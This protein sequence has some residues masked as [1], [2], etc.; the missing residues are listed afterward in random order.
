MPTL[1]PTMLHLLAPFAPCFSRRVWCHALVLVAGAILA[2]GRRTV[3]AA[4]RAMG[5]EH[6]QR[7][8]RYHRVLSR[9]EW[10]GLAV[11]RTLLGLLVAA[12]VPS[13]PLVV[14]VDETVERRRGAQDRGQGDLPR[15]GALQPRPLRQGERAALGLPDAAGAHPVGAPGV[16]AA[17]PD[18]PGPLRAL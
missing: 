12:F 1:P 10:S 3:A 8:E 16:G 7:F 14:G 5:L 2:P 6:D 13:G 9:A 4:L 18:G 11:G 15:R 17:V